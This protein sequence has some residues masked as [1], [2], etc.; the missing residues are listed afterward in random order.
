SSRRRH[1]RF[2]RDWS[3][4]V[5]SSDLLRSMQPAW[6]PAGFEPLDRVLPTVATLGLL[7]STWLA[8]SGLKAIGR[9]SRES[10]LRHWGLAIALGA[11]RKSV[12]EGRRVERGRSRLRRY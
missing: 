7:A 8:H 3:S 11:D 6:P 2:S 12:V 5:C 9:D 4:D 10:F 1:T